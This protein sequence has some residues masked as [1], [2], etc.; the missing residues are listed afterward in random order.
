MYPVLRSRHFFGRLR[1]Q[2]AKVTEPTLAP[3][4]L[5]RLRLQAKKGVSMRLRLRNIACTYQ[6]I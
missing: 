3:T 5:G 4:Y 1:L 6:Y 2:V